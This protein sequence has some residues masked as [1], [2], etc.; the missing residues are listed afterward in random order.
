MML[1]WKRKRIGA[2]W[3]GEAA[4]YPTL[5]CMGRNTICPSLGID[6]CALSTQGTQTQAGM[7][8]DPSRCSSPSSPTNID[9]VPLVASSLCWC[10]LSMWG[11]SA[12]C[13][14]SKLSSYTTTE[15][16]F[17]FCSYVPDLKQDVGVAL[18]WVLVYVKNV[19]P[20]SQRRF[21]KSMLV[22]RSPRN[23]LAVGVGRSPSRG[24]L[25]Q[26]LFNPGI[27]SGSD[28]VISFC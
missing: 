26:A 12:S 11:G 6:T 2:M 3:A 19:P 9:R 23:S 24:G 17:F 18:C 1:L 28:W 7:R 21:M 8:L 15:L 14:S 10:E 25:D 20:R 22:S 16:Y 13:I 4:N 5:S 27:F